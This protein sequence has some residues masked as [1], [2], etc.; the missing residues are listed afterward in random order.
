MTY[1]YIVSTDPNPT[2]GSCLRFVINKDCEWLCGN[3]EESTW[4]TILKKRYGFQGA[5]QHLIDYY[6]DNIHDDDIYQGTGIDG[7]MI[8][9]IDEDELEELYDE[10]CQ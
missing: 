1:Y 8:C 3:N 10:F 9:T 2:K 6:E 5:C 7:C 4:W